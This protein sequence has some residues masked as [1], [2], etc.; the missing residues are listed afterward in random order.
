MV[1]WR[2]GELLVK[3]NI[4]S[5]EQLEAALKK[6]EQLGMPLGEI[7]VS[8]GLIASKMFYQVLAE[9]I[10]LQ[11]VTISDIHI[12][13]QL[14]VR[15]PESIARKYCLLPIDRSFNK[16]ILAYSFPEI[17]IPELEIL[18]W[19]GCERLEKVLADPAE[20]R[21]AICRVYTSGP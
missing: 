14:A 17:E 18:S 4:L 10:G 1:D 5:W 20:L 12:D 13:R 8:S 21:E 15:V 2:V 3:K 6:Q 7:L 19:T 9:K 11:F 16:L